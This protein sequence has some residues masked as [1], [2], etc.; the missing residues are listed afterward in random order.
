MKQRNPRNIYHEIKYHAIELAV[1][2]VF[3]SW[4]AKDVWKQLGF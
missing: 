2:I 3:L 4:L 1:L